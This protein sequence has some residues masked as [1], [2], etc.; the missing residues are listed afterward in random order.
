MNTAPEILA[1]DGGGTRCRIAC[2]ISGKRHEVEVGSANASTDLDGAIVTISDGLSRLASKT[3]VPL[4]AFADVPTYLGL[5]GVVGPDIARA[6]ADGLPLSSIRVEDDR[7]AAVRGALG[8]HD[9]ATVHSGTGSF[10]AIQRDG[11]IKLSGGW[12]HVLGDEASAHWLGR[13]LLIATLDVTDQLRRATP[14]S[15]TVLAR[16][17][18]SAGIVAF[19]TD[20][21]PAEFGSLAPLVTEAAAT[22]DSLAENILQRGADHISRTLIAMGWGEKLPI[23]LTGG[24]AGFYRDYLPQDMQACFSQPLASPIDGALSLAEDFRMELTR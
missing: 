9:G 17:G 4:T 10:F 3:G 18:S 15:D 23:C 13:K 2:V 20:A 11:E 14:L 8:H 12:G 22:G 19:A 21:S 1:A 7:P 5:A 16:F 6:I 24:V